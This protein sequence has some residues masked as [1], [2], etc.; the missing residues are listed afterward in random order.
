[1]LW[2]QRHDNAKHLRSARRPGRMGPLLPRR[3]DARH[4]PFVGAMAPSVA[5]MNR[6]DWALLSMLV[7]VVLLV[8]LRAWGVRHGW[9]PDEQG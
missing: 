1:M 4:N 9:Y 5:V 7:L 8:G 3:S 2:S 6:V